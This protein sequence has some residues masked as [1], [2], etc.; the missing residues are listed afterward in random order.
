L[1][2]K[3]SEGVELDS[4]EG[5]RGSNSGAREILAGKLLAGEV[6]DGQ[7]FAITSEVGHVLRETPFKSVLKLD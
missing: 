5:G 1:L 2:E 7:S 6:V 3:D 4:L